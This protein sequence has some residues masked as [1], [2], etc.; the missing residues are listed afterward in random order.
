MM[1]GQLNSLA[2]AV[3]I[4]MENLRRN[5]KELLFKFFLKGE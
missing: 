5:L 2:G 3:K 1:S 4:E